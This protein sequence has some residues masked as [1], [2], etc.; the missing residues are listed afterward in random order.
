M[1]LW[2][3]N[4]LLQVFSG[5]PVRGEV[6]DVTSMEIDTRRLRSG[7]MFLAF[8][9]AR[10][11]GHDYL[12]D[13]W[14]KGAVL[15]LVEEFQ[16]QPVTQ[17]CVA[18][19]REAL[20]KL[21]RFARASHTETVYI[22][23]T[24]SVGK[25][26]TR[27]LMHHAFSTAHRVYASS[28]NFNNDLGMPLCLAQMGCTRRWD[29][30]IFE[31]GMSKAGEIVPLSKL[32]Q[33]DIALI[34]NV[35]SVHQENFADIAGIARAKAE[36]FRGLKADSL[37][38]VP[39]QKEFAGIFAQSMPKKAK[40]IVYNDDDAD[41]FWHKCA[42][43][44][45]NEQNSPVFEEK[46]R[47]LRRFR[48]NILAITQIYAAKW[49]D[50]RAVLQSLQNW[51]PEAGRGKVQVGTLASGARITLID[52]SYN[53]SLSSMLACLADLHHHQG[54]RKIAVLG[55]MKELGTASNT[56]HQAVISSL[57]NYGF[58]AVFVTGKPFRDHQ[59][60]IERLQYAAQSAEELVEPLSSYIKTGDVV[61]FKGSQSV[62]LARVIS[63][64][65]FYPEGE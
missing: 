6:P 31:M 55:E 9:G 61:A 60:I 34:L 33:P 25:T 12:G 1:S 32:L 15:A 22:A 36:I 26:S 35:R 14:E 63:A 46:E 3:K 48:D 44:A 57:N 20:W 30:A 45:K 7:G 56:A 2:C 38:V 11:D 4:D 28:G 41:F 52:D 18:N 24:G 29:I 42:L 10:V 16:D 21:A 13:A 53:A 58:N 43:F 23:I 50:P 39:N 37:A 47:N 17:I 65:Q 62:G 40:V 27:S 49:G 64:L 54:G 5:C 8:R 51:Q 59:R 19:M